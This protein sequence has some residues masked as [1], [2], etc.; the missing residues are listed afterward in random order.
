MTAKALSVYG[1]GFQ[2]KV[3]Y[4]LLCDKQFLLN[5]VDIVTEDYF[6]SPAHKWIVK[7]ALSYYHKYHTNPTMEVMVSESKK[8]KNNDILKTSVK[9]E[10]KQVYTGT[11]DDIEYVKEEFLN[12]CRNQKMKDAILQSVDLMEQGEFENI[13]KLIDN[14]LKAGQTKEVVHEYEKDV[15]SRYH[16]DDRHPV[17]F[18][19]PTLNKITQGGPGGGDLVVIVSNP[20][21]GKSWTCVAV[22][23]HA[24]ELGKNVMY[25]S[26]ELGET[27][28]GKRFDAYFTGI[29]V[30][31]LQHNTD[32]ISEKINDLKGHIRIKKYPPA[33]TTL[34]TIENHLRR[35]K[36]Q[37]GFVPDIVIIDYL[38]KLGS[39][40]IRKD[41]N[42]EASDIF[43]EAK[44]LAEAL[45]IPI[46]SPAQAN[47]TGS[48]LDII[49]GEHLA[50]TYEKFAIA[51][52]IMT[53]SK[54]SNV[55]YIMG[56][57]YGDDDVAFG[58]TFNRKNGHI[59]I[60]QE[61]Y[62]S[63]LIKA[64]EEETK[65]RVRQKFSKIGGAQ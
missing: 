10:L 18:P 61:E 38:E 48:N 47:R 8:I 13:R 32:I 42:E 35:M 51:D 57:R 28:V 29:D 55:W 43:T 5:I 12:F 20:K 25:Y 65:D 4:S 31:Q 44:G 1:H 36:H 3:M 53:V 59:H 11:L 49:K 63:E 15:Y 19:W 39:S 60:D 58:S 50:G 52:I 46:I 22:A 30:D 26:L 14:A 2:V 62:D 6:D 64:K 27:Y 45:D 54:K 24:A 23:A 41:R 40:K 56:N 7:T 34:A 16:E 21:G 33:K 9:E 37:E 17:E